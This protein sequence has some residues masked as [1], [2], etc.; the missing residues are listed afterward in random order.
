[1]KFKW[2]AIATLAIASAAI[3]HSPYKTVDT[4]SAKAPKFD[5]NNS[6]LSSS[7]IS[8]SP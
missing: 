5:V 2:M 1:M 4:K 3:A 8:V 7:L 6:T